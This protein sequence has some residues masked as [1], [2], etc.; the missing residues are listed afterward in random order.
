MGAAWSG[1]W[2]KS[3]LNFYAKIGLSLLMEKKRGK[4]KVMDFLLC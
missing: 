3:A 4:V 1:I 2:L